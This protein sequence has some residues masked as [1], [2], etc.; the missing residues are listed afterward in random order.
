ML[1]LQIDSKSYMY[2]KISNSMKRNKS[3]RNWSHT[4]SDDGDLWGHACYLVSRL[5][6]SLSSSWARWWEFE[7]LAGDSRPTPLT[8]IGLNAFS[9]V[10]T[11]GWLSVTVPPLP[12]ANDWLDNTAIGVWMFMK[13]SPLDIVPLYIVVPLW[14]LLPLAAEGSDHK[15]SPLMTW[16]LLWFA[17]IQSV[18][19]GK[20]V[21]WL[22][23]GLGLEPVPCGIRWFATWWWWVMLCWGSSLACSVVFILNE[24]SPLPPPALGNTIPSSRPKFLSSWE[25]WKLGLK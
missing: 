11:P 16:L 7:A 23:L 14:L 13:W 21:R 8:G 18:V 6:A 20:T 9:A 15:G 10:R 1:K 17:T 25:A 12:L 3:R 2:S 19:G 22:V 4:P 5:P 24:P